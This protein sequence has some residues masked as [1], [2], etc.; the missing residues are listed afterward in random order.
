[1]AIVPI[2][3]IPNTQYGV[4]VEKAI[5]IA[6][7][8]QDEFIFQ[9]ISSS[10]RERFGF[11]DFK[12]A[13]TYEI[14]DRMESIRVEIGGF[15]PFLLLICDS[16]LIG[17]DYEN[18]FGSNRADKGLGVF[19]THEVTEILSGSSL[20]PYFLYYFGRFSLSF[21][22]IEHKN[23][24]AN[25]VRGCVYDK[26][27]N[28]KDIKE[29][30][31][32]KAICDD[33]REKLFHYKNSLTYRQFD[34]LN[35]IFEKSGE[36]LEEITEISPSVFIG[37]S[38][39]GLEVA[40]KLQMLLEQDCKSVVWNQGVFELGELFLESL[41]RVA[42]NNDFGIFVFTPDDTIESRGETKKIARDN[43][44][45]ELGLFVGK[46]SRRK[47]FIVHPR[48][49]D[50]HILSDFNGIK[51]ASYDAES[52]NLTASLGPA[53]EQIRDSMRRSR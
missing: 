41:E 48:D 39:E 3:V 53:C 42:S 1:M 28:K 37:S 44:I 23:H 33:C 35:T 19:T 10:E 16:Y 4:D 43:V 14:M 18:I 6:N 51:K 40:N 5:S 46:L 45:F 49:S 2:E 24:D 20:T 11:L 12:K 50:L 9:I 7:S 27:I 38:S 30:M 52:K 13:K 22:A 25:E 34:S 8:I 26:K 29:S 47:A 32:A 15:H 31:K 36:L 17:S 21:I